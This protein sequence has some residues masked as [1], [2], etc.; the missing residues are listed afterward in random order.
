MKK[1]FFA[2][3]VEYLKDNPEH[4]WFKRKVFG[5]GWAPATK[6]GW[7]L[8]LGFVAII[9]FLAFRLEETATNNVVFKQLLLPLIGL[10]ILFIFISYKKGEK[11]KWMWHIPEPRED[12]L[13]EDRDKTVE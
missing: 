7:L 3:Y 9:L 10:V 4:Y 6:E 5:W 11:P 8:T 12:S 1:N 2:R 13:D